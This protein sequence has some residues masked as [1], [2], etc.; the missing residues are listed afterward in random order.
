MSSI[1]T[2]NSI[3][4]TK[5]FATLLA[6]V[7]KKGDVLLLSGDLG[8]GKTT[9]SK[10]I[11]SALTGLYEGYVTSPTFG[12]LKYYKINVDTSLIHVD[13]YNVS[14]LDQLYETDILDSF[15]ENITII[16]WPQIIEKRFIFS[17][18]IHIN[19]DDNER[20]FVVNDKL[21]RALNE[22]DLL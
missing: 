9:L 2:V 17:Y 15:E 18:R 6:K 4:E 19:S 1:F 11:V 10:Y 22:K 8:S 21:Y 12:I 14:S 7:L 13:L 5:K 3:A 16:E 20:E